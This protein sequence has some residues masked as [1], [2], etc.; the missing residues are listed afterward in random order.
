M[1]VNPGKL[2]TGDP[3]TVED[4]LL[5]FP[6]LKEVSPALVKQYAI[7][8]AVRRRFD[9]GEIVCEEGAFGSTAFYIVEGRVE[10]YIGNPMSHL[11][12][13]PRGGGL[14]SFMQRMTSMLV[15]EPAGTRS[16]AD[17]RITIDASVDLSRNTPIAT[18]G[19]GELIGEM[20][21]RTFQP[22]S[23]TV[24]A[25]ED[26][27]VV[28][29][30][31]V[32][33][34][35]LVGTRDV[36]PTTK[37]TTKVKAPTFKGTSFRKQMDEQYRS[38][39]LA[40]HLRSVPLFAT[41][42]GEFF[43]YIKEHAELV[44]FSKGEVVCSQGT[45]A[46][47]FYLIRN[48]L[49]RVS[50]KM[51]FVAG[52]QRQYLTD[53]ASGK[54]FWFS[55][56]GE[57]VEDEL[58]RTYLKRG[59]F[60]GEIGLL[61]EQA[62]NATCSALDAV[63]IVKIPKADFQLLLDKFP[64]VRETLG[65]IASARIDADRERKL[66]VGLQL[67]EF[68]DQGL[69]EAQNLLLIDLDHCT[70][71]DACVNACADAHDGVTRLIRDG[72]RYDRFLVATAC[73]S[74]RD[75]LCMTQCPVGSIR[76]KESLEI[77]IEDWCIGCTKCAELCPYGNI[78][79]HGFDVMKDMP[80]VEKK[81]APK[82]GTA[83]AAKAAPAIAAEVKKEVASAKAIPAPGGPAKDPSGAPNTEPPATLPAER[84][85]AAVSKPSAAPAAPRKMERKMVTVQK[86]TTCDLCTQLS[87][88]SCVYACPHD[89]AK[90]VEPTEFLA[91]QIGGGDQEKRRFRWL[92][93]PVDRTTH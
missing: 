64:A 71:C 21:C 43:T 84:K 34:D 78:N 36:D 70:R 49:V 13:K 69:F 60:F 40:T 57:P 9:A 8:A 92:N 93:R 30:L 24:R 77:I 83:P 50:Q 25:L 7:G 1:H 68:I 46:D 82:D 54:Q 11:Q 74:C 72:L 35:M 18:L 31:R 76:R 38:R 29:L 15:A 56:E 66:P 3:L 62:R 23:A 26:C 19:P 41:V 16:A 80:V 89:A 37:A 53:P 48:G 17:Q 32:I 52:E 73:R 61:H 42:D 81:A 87:V 79:M 75:P 90:R 5:Y 65:E 45:Q 10:I 28:E 6:A 44:S 20:S 85:P 63:D 12:T 51:P 4:L 14:A 27:L 86:A 39:S 33:L 59:E 91:R 88:P 2:T 67:V 47:A 55:P 22:R 58:V